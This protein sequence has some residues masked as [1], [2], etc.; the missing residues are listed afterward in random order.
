VRPALRP[1]VL[2]GVV[3]AALL[4]GLTHDW[5]SAIRGVSCRRR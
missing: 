4:L 1:L 3:T 2:A 5:I